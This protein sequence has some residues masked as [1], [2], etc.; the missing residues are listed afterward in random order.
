MVIAA[1]FE[2]NFADA[3][4]ESLITWKKLLLDC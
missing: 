4:D 1:H 2:G 3:F